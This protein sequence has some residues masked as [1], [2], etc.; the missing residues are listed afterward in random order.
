M[1]IR[2]KSFEQIRVP[3]VRR[4]AADG[5][6]VCCAI[7]IGVECFQIGLHRVELLDFMKRRHHETLRFIDADGQKL[8]LVV[9]RVWQIQ[10]AIPACNSLEL[11]L[12]L[13]ALLLMPAAEV[14]EEYRGRDVVILN[15]SAAF[16]CFQYFQ[17]GG[18]S[19][20]MVVNKHVR[21]I[22]KEIIDLVNRPNP[23]NL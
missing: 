6:D 4:D 22:G 18:P 2:R 5:Q 13:T 23:R 21:R 12:T 16:H 17:S 1:V 8:L 10:I 19:D 11:L 15:D 14:W 7:S 9:V 20:W 3:F